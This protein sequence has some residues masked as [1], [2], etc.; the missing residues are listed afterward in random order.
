MEEKKAGKSEKKKSVSNVQE[1]KVEVELRSEENNCRAAVQNVQKA[2]KEITKVGAKQIDNE[3]NDETELSNETDVFFHPLLTNNHAD[4]NDQLCLQGNEETKL[5][6]QEDTSCLSIPSFVSISSDEDYE[7]N[8]PL[9]KKDSIG[10]DWM[11]EETSPE[12][13]Q[14]R[15]INENN[16]KSNLIELRDEAKDIK[17]LEIMNSPE[18][19]TINI[20]K[21]DSSNVHEKSRSNVADNSRA[22]DQN[23]PKIQSMENIQC[24]Q[25][26][27]AQ[28][29]EMLNVEMPESGNSNNPDEESA[30]GDRNLDTTSNKIE[31]N[32]MERTL[33]QIDSANIRVS[34]IDTVMGTVKNKVD[35]EVSDS[36]LGNQNANTASSIVTEGTEQSESQEVE[37]GNGNTT[38]SG[39]EELQ[40]STDA[41]GLLESCTSVTGSLQETVTPLISNE[42]IGSAVED[43]VIQNEIIS[44]IVNRLINDTVNQSISDTV[45]DDVNQK[46]S[47]PEIPK[48][49]DGRITSNES[50]T[51]TLIKESEIVENLPV[52]ESKITCYDMELSKNSEESNDSEPVQ[53][54][55][56]FYEAISGFWK[57]AGFSKKRY[58]TTVSS[59]QAR[60]LSSELKQIP[61]IYSSKTSLTSTESLGTLMSSSELIKSS[62]IP[63]EFTTKVTV[64]HSESNSISLLPEST[65]TDIINDTITSEKTL[66]DHQ[67]SR[68]SLNT[69][70]ENLGFDK[71][72]DVLQV[73]TPDSLSITN[74]TIKDSDDSFEKME[75]S[76]KCKKAKA[77]ST[78]LSV[79]GHK[80]R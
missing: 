56:K 15:N 7:G 51:I 57:Y 28:M 20:R 10:N 13:I 73:E 36:I 34:K 44:D 72:S 80:V 14:E 52:N 42:A 67:L 35:I 74:E 53:F 32:V 26:S 62:E 68:D 17:A 4:S 18:T 29:S 45:D 21:S 79:F 25:V 11:I 46:L 49:N 27:E 66:F 33:E 60:N 54:K 58:Y 1:T 37:E 9:G 75:D 2:T 12:K 5:H 76:K 77:E 70:T 48:E 6:H 47:S 39:K 16:S 50:V 63:S 38:E 61:S 40:T 19:E 22:T 23:T 31:A 65:V 55:N 71:I 59:G 69:V 8:F 64:P 78:N 24:T 30:E 43:Y 41:V 3:F